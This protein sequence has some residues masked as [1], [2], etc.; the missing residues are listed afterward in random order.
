ML[1]AIE[2]R[3]VRPAQAPPSQRVDA[4]ARLG[5]RGRGR[6]HR[7]GCWRGRKA[8]GPS[9]TRSVASPSRWTQLRDPRRS[10]APV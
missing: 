7:P 8:T 3:P 5:R 10:P 2:R 1:A 9:R 4:I 6:E